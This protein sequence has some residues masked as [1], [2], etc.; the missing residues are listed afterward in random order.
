MV[1]PQNTAVPTRVWV[2]L[3]RKTDPNRRDGEVMRITVT[4]DPFWVAPGQ[5]VV[6][7]SNEPFAVHFDEGVLHGPLVNL[8][9]GT[10]DGWPTAV[11]CS[12]EKKFC[13]GQLA[14]SDAARTEPYKYTVSVYGGDGRVYIAD[15]EGVV[16][17]DP[18]GTRGDMT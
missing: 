16:D 17:P 18:V 13:Y 6:F 2:E 15:P 12:E 1:N 4:P 3:D 5:A 11:D 9:E 10:P 7:E 14:R 8:K